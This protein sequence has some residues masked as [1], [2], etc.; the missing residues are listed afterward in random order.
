VGVDATSVE[1]VPEGIHV[2]FIIVS[3]SNEGPVSTANRKTHFLRRHALALQSQ[4]L[5]NELISGGHPGVA[6]DV[7]GEVLRSLCADA[8]DALDVLLLCLLV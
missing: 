3:P 6:V 1:V 7:L 4:K 2:L 8:R 5:A